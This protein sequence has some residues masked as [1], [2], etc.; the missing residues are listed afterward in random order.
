MDE[1]L[2][3]VARLL[4]GE[5]MTESVT[6]SGKIGRGTEHS[7][8]VIHPSPKADMPRGRSYPCVRYEALPMSRVGHAIRP[9]LCTKPTRIREKPHPLL[10][11]S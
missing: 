7:F 1:R 2:R 4:Q 11:R 10:E 6:I 8:H 3:F 5:A 9:W